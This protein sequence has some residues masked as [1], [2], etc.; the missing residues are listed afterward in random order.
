MDLNIGNVDKDIILLFDDMRISSIV[1]NLLTNAIKFS[2]VGGNI[3]IEASLDSAQ[4]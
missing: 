3:K 1:Q 4:S 2:P